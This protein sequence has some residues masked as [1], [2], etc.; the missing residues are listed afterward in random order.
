M[1][2]R[3]LLK[4]TCCPAP[5]VP[6][7]AGAAAARAAPPPEVQASMSRLMM[8]PPG[9][10]P[11]TEERSMFSWAAM[12]LAR[13]LALRRPLSPPLG[14]PPPAPS[15]GARGEAGWGGGAGSRLTEDAMDPD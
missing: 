13:G 3:M 4:G 7:G 9:P 6:P 11:S 5:G 12:L 8:R 1:V 15:P 14:A 2:L 10:L